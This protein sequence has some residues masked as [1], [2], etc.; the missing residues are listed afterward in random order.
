MQLLGERALPVPPLLV[1]ETMERAR[2]RLL[3]PRAAVQAARA[4]QAAQAAQAVQAV[5][6]VQVLRL[7]LQHLKQ[8]EVVVR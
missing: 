8:L 7:R 1:A 4:V 3:P 2:L 6:V 5:R